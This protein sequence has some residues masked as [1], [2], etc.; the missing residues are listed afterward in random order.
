MS[1]SASKR[2][3]PMT[4]SGG[5]FRAVSPASDQVLQQSPQS[6]KKKSNSRHYIYLNS[7]QTFNNLKSNSKLHLLSYNQLNKISTNINSIVTPRKPKS[8][9]IK[10]ISSPPPQEDYVSL[11]PKILGETL[12]KKIKKPNFSS[13]KRQLLMDKFRIENE[14]SKI[15]LSSPRLESIWHQT[16]TARSGAEGSVQERGPGSSYGPFNTSRRMTTPHNPRFGLLGEIADLKL[17]E[18]EVTL[19]LPTDRLEANSARD[20]SADGKASV[21]VEVIHAASMKETQ[22]F[23]DLLKDFCKVV[24]HTQKSFEKAEKQQVELYNFVTVFVKE[25]DDLEKIPKEPKIRRLNGC[26]ESIEQKIQELGVEE[27]LYNEQI[28]QLKELLA[29]INFPNRTS[30]YSSPFK[31]QKAPPKSYVSSNGEAS[32]ERSSLIDVKSRYDSPHVELATSQIIE[33]E[34]YSSIPAAIDRIKT[35]TQ[36]LKNDVQKLQTER[37]KYLTNLQNQKRDRV[38]KVLDDPPLRIQP[39]ERQTDI[40]TEIDISHHIYR[41]AS[42][43]NNVPLQSVLKLEMFAINEQSP[44]TISSRDGAAHRD[45]PIIKEEYENAPKSKF[46]LLNLSHTDSKSSKKEEFWISAEELFG[47]LQHVLNKIQKNLK[48]EMDQ[49][50]VFKKDVDQNQEHDAKETNVMMK[51]IEFCAE[52][53]LNDIRECLANLGAKRAKFLEEVLVHVNALNTLLK[54]NSLKLKSLKNVM[55]ASIEK[56][57]ETAKYSKKYSHPDLEDKPLRHKFE[58]KYGGLKAELMEYR[59]TLLFLAQQLNLQ[60]SMYGINQIVRLSGNNLAELRDG[61]EN[62][63]RTLYNLNKFPGLEAE[64]NKKAGKAYLASKE[65]R[66]MIEGLEEFFKESQVDI[67]PKLWKGEEITKDLRTMHVRIL[68]VRHELELM[69]KVPML[70]SFVDKPLLVTVKLIKKLDMNEKNVES[71]LKRIQ[72]ELTDSYN[73]LVHQC[74]E[75]DKQVN[76]HMKRFL[77]TKEHLSFAEWRQNYQIMESLKSEG[78]GLEE[79][80]KKYLDKVYPP[81]VI[82]IPKP[83]VKKQRLIEIKKE[84]D[85]IMETLRAGRVLGNEYFFSYFEGIKTSNLKDKLARIKQDVKDEL[86]HKEHV[87]E[88]L[89]QETGLPR[90]VIDE[91]RNVLAN[92]SSVFMKAFELQQNISKEYAD[93]HEEQQVNNRYWANQTILLDKQRERFPKLITTGS[94]DNNDKFSQSPSGDQSLLIDED[95]PFEDLQIELKKRYSEQTPIHSSLNGQSTKLENA[96][97]MN[98]FIAKLK[99]LFTEFLDENVAVHSGKHILFREMLNRFQKMYH[100]EL[101]MLQK[102]QS[103]V[104]NV[105]VNNVF[106]NKEIRPLTKLP[107]CLNLLD[108]WEQ[109]M[110]KLLVVKEWM[111]NTLKLIKSFHG[112]ENI[113]RG[114][115]ETHLIKYLHNQEVVSTSIDIVLD[116][117]SLGSILNE[118]ELK[119]KLGFH[120]RVDD[121]DMESFLTHLETEFAEVRRQYR[122]SYGLVEDDTRKL[123]VSL[124][125]FIKAF[126]ALLRFTQSKYK[127]L[128]RI[129]S[130]GIKPHGNDFV[131]YMEATYMTMKEL[132]DTFVDGLNIITNMTMKPTWIVKALDQ[133]YRQ[134]ILRD[135][136][137]FAELASSSKDFEDFLKDFREEFIEKEVKQ[138]LLYKK[139]S[140]SNPIKCD[141]KVEIVTKLAQNLQ[142]HIHTGEVLCRPELKQILMAKMKTLQGAKR[143]YINFAM[144]YS[145]GKSLTDKMQPVYFIKEEHILIERLLEVEIMVNDMTKHLAK[146]TEECKIIMKEFDNQLDIN[147]EKVFKEEIL[148]FYMDLKL[149]LKNV[150]LNLIDIVDFY[151]E[152]KKTFRGEILLLR[153]DWVSFIKDWVANSY[154]DL[155]RD[156]KPVNSGYQEFKEKLEVFLQETQKVV[157]ATQNNFKDIVENVQCLNDNFFLEKFFIHIEEGKEATDKVSVEINK[158]TN[159]TKFDKWDWM[160]MREK[161]RD[162]IETGEKVEKSIKF[163]NTQKIVSTL[164]ANGIKNWDIVQDYYK[165]K[166][167]GIWVQLLIF[168]RHELALDPSDGPKMD[169]FKDKVQ[170]VEGLYLYA[171]Q[172]LRCQLNPKQ[173]EFL[174]VIYDWMKK[175]FLDEK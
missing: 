101:E 13:E 129:I 154:V 84:I 149:W 166:G 18:T 108:K 7:L 54:S 74:E 9:H 113:M 1:N 125:E 26:V 142:Y 39:S 156:L 71:L 116:V 126:V 174:A 104:H 51:Q 82:L 99:S 63:W 91:V 115:I 148:E 143:V 21:Y 122:L 83:E 160:D 134:I 89:N 133:F 119:L 65:A 97:K 169:R 151:V 136:H 165:S 22:A 3:R 49:I 167:I 111:Q 56:L 109:K 60:L 23:G 163:L 103:A 35:K 33:E 80:L 140:E 85:S 161:C 41:A 59:K 4:A 46:G 45:S 50:K 72:E 86:G 48:R 36:E 79:M 121:S 107:K 117:F 96:S 6:A 175:L 128:F 16:L 173:K 17:K 137:L 130:E 157:S 93:F 95:Q 73:D 94:I 141:K 12:P 38:S 27:E 37:I 144:I 100:D 152:L 168:T 34:R 55:K 110:D 170:T 20:A 64:Y 52:I 139:I 118:K 153:D 25:I 120:I 69:S 90:R 171:E 145:M 32:P 123:M 124:E 162:I 78:I 112:E 147:L 14:T 146:A 172:A 40:G 30:A 61:F 42:E 159:H 67:V 138:K 43:R 98:N 127:D 8:F 29:E 87:I 70:E 5:Q 75:L 81:R 57:L 19:E 28:A 76:S 132:T 102:V 158:L 88:V 2:I 66:D 24:A 131:K 155:S 15:Q 106:Y 10:K 114:G 164:F 31:L 150:R 92:L 58:A 44:A 47:Y 105:Q 135:L 62:I 77:S 68:N 53:V 11:D